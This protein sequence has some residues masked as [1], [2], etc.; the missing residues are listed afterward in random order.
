MGIVLLVGQL[1]AQQAWEKE[2][3]CSRL[4]ASVTLPRS[5]SYDGPQPFDMLHYRLDLRIAMTSD[6]LAGR[7][8]MTMRLKENVDTLVLHAVGLALDTLRVDGVVRQTVTDSTRE[9]FTILLG[10]TRTAGETL[11][12]VIDYRRLQGYRR[13]SS[14]QG[15]YFFRDSIGLPANLGYT[16][17]EP[18]DAR[19]WF[20]CYDEPWEKA[21]AE[22]HLSVPSGYV[23]A[24]NGR[25]TGT[26][27]NGDGTV[28]WHWEQHQPI[29][30][31]LMCLTISRFAVSTIPYVRLSGDTIPLQ[32]YAWN[33][34]PFV[35]SAWTAS[36]LPTI[37]QL[38][39]AYEARFGA[40]PFDKYGMT[41]IVPFSYLGMEHQ[42]LTTMNR[43]FATSIRVASHELAHQWWG[44]DVTCGT[45]RDIW[46]NEGFATYGEALWREHV[47]GRDSLKKYMHDTLAT[48]QF[49]SWQGAVYDPVGQGFN[50]FDQVV[51]T[52]AAWVLHT[53]RGVVGDSAFFRILR[54]YRNA[55]Q[56]R[57]ATTDDLNAVVDSV[58]GT[59]MGWFFD[60]WIYG[61]GWPKYGSRFAWGGDTLRLTIRQQQDPTWPTFRMPMRVRAYHGA[62]HTDFLV[63]DSLRAQTFVLP[64]AA[65]PDSVVLDPDG[66]I[67]KQVVAF[68]DV[69][70]TG[71][72]PTEFRL[73]QNYPNPFYAGGDGAFGR[74][75]T[76][77]IRFEVRDSRFV[78]LRVYDVLGR[79]VARLVH[80]ALSPG[81]YTVRFDGSG[82]ASGVYYY[83][84][85]LVG[86][87]L[88]QTKAML[89][90]R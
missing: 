4:I 41:A 58:V 64:L 83:R 51:Y 78:S 79:E 30:T 46:L 52:K 74:S 55:Y 3:Q 15:Y 88:I 26:T 57:S 73:Y 6:S 76:T 28:T 72:Q 53:L 68:T 71:A 24:S 5:P 32:Y 89:L 45:W 2:A 34:P 62:Q 33:A 60:Q 31:Y 20:P 37:A 8:S 56:G 87:N 29:A 48:F 21:T 12:V 69:T 85:H 86:T 35:D 23:A 36:F 43:Y 50:L 59:D 82:L 1:A 49:V 40:Y 22:F 54:A 42:T 13:Q 75:S 25:L 61:R 39:S 14:R 77:N 11:R 44:D 27:N 90:I 17:S 66:W 18:S 70:E 47:G 63:W 81:E 19:F 7:C 16:F 80:E 84:L 38:M 10:N 9:T 65:P 67:L